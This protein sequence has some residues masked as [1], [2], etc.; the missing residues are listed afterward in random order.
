[1]DG[2]TAAEVTTAAASTVSSR[3]PRVPSEREGL[4]EAEVERLRK[5][6]LV[7]EGQWKKKHRL[8]LFALVAIPLFI[9]APPLWGIGAL[10]ATPCL[11]ATQ[12]YLIGMRRAECRELILQTQ[13]DLATL[14]ARG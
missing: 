11:V 5:Q 6:L 8:A 3:E 12:A 10:M 7:L 1:M 13:R 14:R 9:F 2:H 4:L